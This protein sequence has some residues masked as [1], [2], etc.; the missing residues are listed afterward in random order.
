MATSDPLMSGVIGFEIDK[1][2]EYF[3]GIRNF[4]LGG[5]VLTIAEFA[6]AAKLTV[7]SAPSELNNNPP[8]T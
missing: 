6:N 2:A 1:S 8:M 7:E 3:A 4:A 5:V